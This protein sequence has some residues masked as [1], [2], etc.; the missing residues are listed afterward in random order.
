MRR[1][2][3]PSPLLLNLI[4]EWHLFCA[5][6]DRKATSG[7]SVDEQVELMHRGLSNSPRRQVKAFVAGTTADVRDA[8]WCDWIAR[9]VQGVTFGGDV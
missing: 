5:A 1:L 8:I 6:T 4:R 7:M 9:L 2:T 3:S